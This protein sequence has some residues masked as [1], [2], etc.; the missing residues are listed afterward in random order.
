MAT[1]DKRRL[2]FS[3]KA[4]YRAFTG[5]VLAILGGFVG[6]FLLALSW[7]DPAGF[8]VLRGA[9]SE[10]AAP[11]SGTLA[12]A[13]S[14]AQN[15][16]QEIAAYFDAGSKNAELQRELDDS[17]TQLVEARALKQENQRL[18]R[19]LELRQTEADPVTIARL[20]SSSASST[21]RFA[22]M[23]AGSRQGV[24]RGQPVRA[25]KGLIGRVVETTPN[26]AR[27]LLLTDPRNVIPVKRASDGVVAFTEGLG[28]G[29]VAIRLINVGVNPFKEGDIM[30]TSGSGGLYRPNIPVAVIREITSD[31]ALATLL[32]DP[33]ATDFVMV[34]KVY[35]PDLVSQESGGEGSRPNA[36]DQAAES[37]EEAD[38][39]DGAE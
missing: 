14:G 22:T 27:V 32:S 39:G 4:H 33:A 12:R 26:T 7:I 38:S 37:G 25:P 6:L 20:I 21:R 5:Y 28:N 31:G 35:Q 2:G 8:S 9:A 15:G 16:W 17:R 24:E 3:R 10:A 36:G 11:V 23:G 19:L 34:Q 1:P 29:D 13:R 30:V 18:R